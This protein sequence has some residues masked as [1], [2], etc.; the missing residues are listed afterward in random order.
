[1]KK[2]TVKRLSAQEISAENIPTL[3]ADA[4]VEYHQVNCVNWSDEF[5]Y[6]PKINFGIAHTGSEI[7]LHYCVEERC[8]RAV[9]PQD[10]G[11]VWE[12]SC[13]EFFIQPATDGIYYNIECNCA[14]TLLV[15]SGSRREERQLAPQSILDQV[16]RWSSL[17]RVPFGTKDGDFKWQMAL[18]IPVTTFFQH[19]I[20]QLDSLQVKANFYK[21]GDK[22]STPHF[23]SWAPIAVPCPD[24]HRPDFFGEIVFEP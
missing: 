23:L 16:K 6:A 7:W 20:Q 18:I 1:M 8:I 17:G 2:L 9:A 19:R 10:N 14:G 4:G 24:F 11:K 12:D 13:C 3:L 21:C 15:G 5:P 22:T